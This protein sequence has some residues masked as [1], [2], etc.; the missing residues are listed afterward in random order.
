[1]LV[2]PAI[3]RGRIPCRSRV[4]R[5][6]LLRHRRLVVARRRRVKVSIVCDLEIGTES[7]GE[8]VNVVLGAARMSPRRGSLDIGNV[9]VL[10]G[11][12]V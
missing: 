3:H 7:L 11:L 1:M 6:R 5:W 2:I 12:L 9:E 4:V 10:G 8:I